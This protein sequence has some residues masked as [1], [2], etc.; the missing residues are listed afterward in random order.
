[1]PGPPGVVRHGAVQPVL[2]GQGTHDPQQVL[3]FAAGGLLPA[4]LPLGHQVPL[5]VTHPQLLHPPRRN[6]Q[7]VQEQQESLDGLPLAARRPLRA[8]PAAG[9]DPCPQC[10]CEVPVHPGKRQ[11]IEP[12]HALAAVLTG[13]AHHRRPA[14]LG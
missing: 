6:G 2:A 5:Q 14:V 11:L 13:E 3:E 7:L 1:M 10:V 12:E 8:A 9:P 4:G